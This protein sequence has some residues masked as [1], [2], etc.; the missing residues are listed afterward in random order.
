MQTGNGANPAFIGLVPRLSCEAY[1]IPL[2][3]AE[4]KH[5]WSYNFTP[6]YAYIGKLYLSH[7]TILTTSL[8]EDDIEFIICQRK[9]PTLQEQNM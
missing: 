8:C 2:S 4:V 9:R 6:P 5:E 7:R 1:Q 3:T